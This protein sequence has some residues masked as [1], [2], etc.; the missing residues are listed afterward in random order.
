MEQEHLHETHVQLRQ[1][2]QIDA[3]TGSVALALASIQPP[4]LRFARAHESERGA[5]IFY[6]VQGEGRNLG[7]PVVFARLSGCNLQCTW[8]DTPYTWNFEGTDFKHDEDK[9]YVKEDETVTLSVDDA[10]EAVS[11]YGVKRLVIT[12]GEPMLQQK[13]LKKFVGS[14]RERNEEQWVEIETNGTIAPDAEFASLVNQ[15]NV[16]VKLENSGN[17]ENRRLRHTAL[18]AFAALEKADFKFV[19]SSDADMQEILFLTELYDI[20]SHRVYLMPEGRTRE[21][22]ETRQLELVEIAKQ[23]NFNLTTRL[24][25]LLWGA[26]R[27]V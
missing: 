21:E 9:K 23:Y 22:I 27:G 17:K 11:A 2:Q 4:E 7:S 5:E 10:V 24:H 15:F 25:V 6:T 3:A 14:L 1:R 16:S 19:V 12:G 20:P 13:T 18:T 26:R 8:C